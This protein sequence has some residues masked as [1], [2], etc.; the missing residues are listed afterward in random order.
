[1]TKRQE[2]LVTALTVCAFVLGII[3]CNRLWFRIDLTKNRSYTIAPV[4]RALY[5]EIPDRLRL[6]YYVSDRLKAVYPQPGE[7][8]D[9]LREYAAYSHNKIQ[10]TIEDPAKTNRT[11]AV[12]SLGIIPQQIQTIERDEASVATVYTGIVIEYLDRVEVMPVVFSLDTL[13]YDL[14]SRIRSMI[15]DQEREIAILVGDSQRTLESDYQFLAQALDGAGYRIVV[16]NTHDEIPA[17]IAVLAVLGGTEDLDEESR[18]RI[19]QYIQTGGSL[20][21]ALDGVTVDSENTMQ[22]WESN[23]EGLVAQVAH[24]GARVEPALAADQAANLVQFQMGNQI[25]LVR[26]PLWIAVLPENS[27]QSHPVTAH[28]SGLDLFWAS[29]VTL[30]APAGVDAVQLFST[31]P[32]AWLQTGSFNINPDFSNYKNEER[33]SYTL[34]AAFS[35]MFPAFFTAKPEHGDSLPDMPSTARSSRIIVI[36][37]SDLFSSFIQATGSRRNLD[38]FVQAVDWLSNDEDIITIRNRS[39]GT[40]RLDKISDPR[41]RVFAMNFS[42]TLNVIIIPAII[43]VTGILLM[44]RRRRGTEV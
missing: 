31:T 12:E 15:R 17:G 18:Y 35:G 6:S 2:L 9:L 30:E 32:T 3:V 41:S 5:A 39:P 14:T 22:A 40:G 25:R 44:W 28:F 38:F 4:S 21:F 36:G 1:M 19:D 10:L 23:R 42:R 11:A 37:D 8:E 16:L 29:P 43:A 34:A 24:Y 7:I 26:Y 13:E 27:N 33:A 20:L